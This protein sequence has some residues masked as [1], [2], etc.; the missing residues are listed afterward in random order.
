M[1]KFLLILGITLTASIQFEASAQ[2]IAKEWNEELL[3]AIRNSRARP[4]VHARNLYHWS[5]AIHDCKAAYEPGE[6]TFFLGKTLEGY[7]SVFKGV[8]EPAD[9]KVALEKAISFASYRLMKHRYKYSPKYNRILADLK[10]FMRTKG[11]DFTDTSTQYVNGNPAHLGNY[12][13]KEIIDYGM[14]DGANEANNYSNQ[15]YTPLNDTLNLSSRGTPGLRKPNHWQPL[16]I[17]TR[18]DQAGNPI[19][20]T[21]T[22]L[23]PEWGEVD[24]FALADSNR[25]KKIRQNTGEKYYTYLDPGPPPYIDT[26]EPGCLDSEYKWGFCMVSIWQSHL[27]PADTTTWDVSPG[28]IGNL[29]DSESPQSFK[30]YD[31][32]YNF[33]EGGGPGF[34][35]GYDTNPVT[36]KPYPEQEVK[37]ADY[38]RILAEYW[39]DGVASETPP[40]HWF[41]IYNKIENDSLFTKQWAGQG[42]TLS[43]LKYDIRAYFTLG[44]AMHDAAVAAWSVKGWYDFV[45]P[46]SA[47]RWMASEGQCTDPNKKNFDS[48]GIPLI[49]GYIELVEKGDP[50][51]GTNNQ[52]VGE[53]KMYTWRGHDYIN[54][55][56]TDTAG[57]GWI[58]AGNWWPYQKPSFVTPPFPG[59]V[60]GHSTFSRA[61]SRVMT[62][63]TGSPY[64]PGGKSNFHM[65]KN[66]FLEH[67][68]GPTED[69]YLQYATYKGASDYTSLS[70]I[71][72]GIHPP[73]DD[74]NGR[75]MGLKTGNYA[76]D[77]ADKLFKAKPP[78]VT[79]V[80]KSD[81]VINKKDWDSTL[82]LTI[83]FSKPMSR[84]GLVNVDYANQDPLKSSLT[85]QHEQWVNSKQYK[86]T[87]EID[88]SRKALKDIYLTI[89]SAY[90]KSGR[91]L[92]PFVEA[93]PFI[94]N[95]ARPRVSKAIPDQKLITDSLRGS[96]FKI[97][98]EFNEAMDT[99]GT[100]DFN[101]TQNQ[102]LNHKPNQSSW[103]SD[104]E[105]VL[106]FQVQDQDEAIDAVGLNIDNLT[107]AANNELKTFD[108]GN[109]FGVWMVNP[110]NTKSSKSTKMLKIDDQGQTSLKYQLS[111]SRKMDTSGVPRLSFRNTDEGVLTLNIQQSYWKD[112]SSCQVAYRLNDGVKKEIYDVK[113]YL[114]LFQGESGNPVEKSK[115][116]DSLVIDT[117]RPKITNVSKPSDYISRDDIGLNGFQIEVEYNEEMNQ[118]EKPVVFLEG[119]D[120]LSEIIEY[121]FVISDWVD[122]QR[123]VAR[124]NITDSLIQVKDFDLRFNFGE[125]RAGNNQEVVVK[126]DWLNLDLK[127]PKILALTAD[128][129]EVSPGVDKVSLFTVYDKKM[130]T[131]V[132][133]DWLFKY[134]GHKD[135]IGSRQDSLSQWVTP[136]IYKTAFDIPDTDLS[137]P[138]DVY[139]FEAKDIA[140]NWIDTFRKN[141]FFQLSSTKY[142]KDGF[143]DNLAIFPNPVEKDKGFVKIKVNQTLKNVSAK[144]FS[145]QGKLIQRK[146]FPVMEKGTHQFPINKV[147][148][149]GMYQLVINNAKGEQGYRI[150]ILGN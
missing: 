78:H 37:R 98:L 70:R 30:N 9:K 102:T 148:S 104:S 129:Y 50:L 132:E 10:D 41:A 128:K 63:I 105:Y 36:G 117:K 21:Q 55:P 1:K 64:F 35:R 147:K 29:K 109:L 92:N 81:S 95:T 11:Y 88:S 112:T 99:A 83:H 125:D 68:N 61:A 107:D 32:F 134:K 115:L 90:S 16:Q 59:Y 126:K 127:P 76:F 20:S 139:Q 143:S 150:I 96:P 87:Y 51:A 73:A 40:G 82:S 69:V 17:T 93:R 5:I 28:N 66:E 124:F 140:G 6:P 53:I 67:E 94:I 57:V 33:K 108:T 14:Q 34:G 130:D 75:E 18:R 38:A 80:V 84:S 13:A 31:S 62:K 19:K 2:S 110:R 22:A 23:S 39:A 103:V 54:D 72:G 138:L 27:D 26:S 118:S 135:I 91:I 65:E 100:P 137:G 12:V 141:A 74:L 120:A 142:P 60:S 114:D 71:W 79:K 25:T 24:P 44:G 49:P 3:H 77:K 111:F 144:L 8:P 42:D 119:S 47:I 86:L 122:S 89:D 149:E 46:V 58:L 123:F 56:E 145:M 131:T 106:S 113:A 48:A 101:L 4:T 15:K 146:A 133:P 52:N 7:E 45:R 116:S 121:D 43:D 136:F 97:R 85:L